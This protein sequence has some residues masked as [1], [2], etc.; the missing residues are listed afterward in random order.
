MVIGALGVGEVDRDGGS[1]NGDGDG[2][3]M[4]G[5]GDATGDKVGLSVL[6]LVRARFFSVRALPGV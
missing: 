3:G 4:E 5:E 1:G 2:E 6:D